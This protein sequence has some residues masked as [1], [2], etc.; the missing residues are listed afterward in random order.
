[1]TPSAGSSGQEKPTLQIESI[2]VKKSIK[3]PLAKTD[4][5]VMKQKP[6]AK[7]NLTLYLISDKK[8]LWHVEFESP[9]NHFNVGEV[10]MH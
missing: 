2:G 4:G 8:E 5:D 3:I 1:M 9:L 6:P 10:R 7:F